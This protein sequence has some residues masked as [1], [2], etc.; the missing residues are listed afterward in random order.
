MSVT[1][2]FFKQLG[3]K[4]CDDF[5]GSFAGPDDPPGEWQYLTNLKAIKDAGIKLAIVEFADLNKLNIAGINYSSRIKSLPYLELT[6]G[7]NVNNSVIYPA[8]NSLHANDIK[9]WILESLKKVIP[10]EMLDHPLDVNIND[11]HSNTDVESNPNVSVLEQALVEDES[12]TDDMPVESVS[13]K[14]STKI[15]TLNKSADKTI[16]TNGQPSIAE[17]VSKD[18]WLPYILGGSLLLVAC[19][20]AGVLIG[21]KMAD[22]ENRQYRPKSRSKVI[23]GNPYAKHKITKVTLPNDTPPAKE[24]AEE[25]ETYLSY[26]DSEDDEPCLLVTEEGSPIDFAQKLRDFT[27]KWEEGPPSSFKKLITR[28]VGK[29]KKV[30]KATNVVNSD[31][32]N[33]ETSKQNETCSLDSI[34]QDVAAFENPQTI[35]NQSAILE[36]IDRESLGDT[37]KT[38]DDVEEILVTRAVENSNGD[39]IV[40]ESGEEK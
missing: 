7:G 32:V 9:I 40:V 16:I 21:S 25:E 15:P 8:A 39:L 12:T 22:R 4:E 20:V 13:T 28:L 38:N 19:T 26:D 34:E 18:P 1:L 35:I 24:I 14:I 29:P 30:V 5:R 33:G 37:F 10:S 27:D 31:V 2:T 17:T 6:Y 11:Q 3:S 23:G 36:S